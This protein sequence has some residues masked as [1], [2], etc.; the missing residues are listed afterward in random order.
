MEKILLVINAHKPD[1]RSIDF[2]CNIAALAHTKLTGVFIENLYFEYIP[3]VE[4]KHLSY[5]ETVKEKA[6]GKVVADT[7]QAITIFKDQCRRKGIIAKTYVD[8]GEPINE[9]TFESRFADLL[10]VDPALGFYDGQEQLPSYFVKQILAK[11]ECPVLL[12]PEQFESAD[13]IVFC[14]DASASAV[15]AIKQFTYLF[16]EFRSKNIMLLEV[17]KTDDKEFGEGHR[18]VMDWLKAHYPS[19]SYHALKGDVKNELFTYFFMKTKKIIVMGAYGRS[20]LSNFFKKS[21]ADKLMRT[22]DLPLFIA[23]P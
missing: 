22:I 7:E 11:S 21:N 4:A 10:L 17:N 1:Q 19:V 8:K 3:M 6:R 5:F 23:H 18:R 20:W 14:Y 16:P 15:F 2:A 9:I 13:E 12:V